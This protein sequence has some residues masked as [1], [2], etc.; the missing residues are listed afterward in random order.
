LDKPFQC[1]KCKN[2]YTP[3]TLSENTFCMLCA[4]GTHAEDPTTGVIDCHFGQFT[5]TL[6]ERNVATAHNKAIAARDNPGDA[7][8][9]AQAE[10]E[11]LNLPEY[12]EWAGVM[13]MPGMKGERRDRRFKSI[14]ALV[15]LVDGNRRPESDLLVLKR[16]VKNC[17]EMAAEIPGILAEARGEV[18][19][20]RTPTPAKTNSNNNVELA[21]LRKFKADAMVNRVNMA[22][23]RAQTR[24]NKKEKA[25]VSA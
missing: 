5:A 12:M 17:K 16:S 3:I 24:K 9:L 4:E 10:A 13:E 18:I 19:Y 15:E 2:W 25:A 11:I 20:E 23:A 21:E 14:D 8:L 7:E 1:D 22:R 6:S